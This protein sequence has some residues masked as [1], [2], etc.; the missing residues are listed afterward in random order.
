[1]NS[2]KPTTNKPSDDELIQRDMNDS[3]AEP[4]EQPEEE[5]R[6]EVEDDDRFQATDN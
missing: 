1:M 5:V 6:D 3:G 2:E 4:S